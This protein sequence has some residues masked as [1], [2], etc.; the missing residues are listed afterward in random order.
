MDRIEFRHAIILVT[1]CCCS[2]AAASAEGPGL[3]IF[4]DRFAALAEARETCQA[5]VLHFYDAQRNIYVGANQW[6]SPQER[7]R[8]FYSAQPKWRD[9]ALN[10]AVV[11]LLPMS[12]WRGPATDLGVTSNEGLASLSPFELKQVD[13]AS[14][15]GGLVFR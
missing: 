12:E 3:R 15:W 1:A 13:P 2:H 4:E 8:L 9:K 5:L 7:I 10:E 11:L 6:I 14:K